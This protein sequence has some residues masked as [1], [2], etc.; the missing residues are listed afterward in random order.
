[1]AGEDRVINFKF[2]SLIRTGPQLIYGGK[3]NSDLNE[4][5]RNTFTNA[6][7]TIYIKVNFQ[8]IDPADA[9][10]TYGDTDDTPSNPSKKKIQK[11][12]PGEFERF[13][14]TLLRSAQNFWNGKFWLETP[15]SYDDLNYPDDKSTHR[16][17]L[18]CRLELEQ[19]ASV[20]ESHYS[21]AVVRVPDSED[22]RSNS[23]L[24]SQKDLRSTYMI[25]NSTRKFWTH[26]HEVG[27]LLG[28]G[29]VGSGTSHNR[30]NDNSDSAYGVTST[31]LQDVMGKGSV[32]K[33]WH[34]LPW[35][36]AAEQFTGVAASKWKVHEHRFYPVRISGM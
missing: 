21:I 13:T 10:G 27:H 28:L 32:R 7:L 30:H 9:V 22:F 35:Q 12:R 36:E 25:P 11:W 5:V 8:K 31:E 14:S 3:W 15:S 33:S 23:V 24:Y 26:Y 16:C 18:Y 29:H 20:A 6:D 19:V 17:N 1:M 4:D 34:A 2:G